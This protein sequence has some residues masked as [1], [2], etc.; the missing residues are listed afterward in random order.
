[1]HTYPQQQQFSNNITPLS[2]LS[3]LSIESLVQ[4]A[5]Q[6]GITS[7]VQMSLPPLNIPL[8]GATPSSSSLLPA[9]FNK[10]NN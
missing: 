10:N 2:S 6:S 3:A 1:M 9:S 8:I 4:T 5:P 7:A